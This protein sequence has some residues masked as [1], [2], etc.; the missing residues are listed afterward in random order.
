[1]IAQT[2]IGMGHNLGLSVIAEGVENEEQRKCLEHIGCDA[3]QGYHFNRPSPLAEFEQL[4][5]QVNTKEAS[6]EFI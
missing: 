6:K 3:F 4:V 2:I 5:R 1:M